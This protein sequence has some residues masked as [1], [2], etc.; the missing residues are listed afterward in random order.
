MSNNICSLSCDLALFVKRS[1]RMSEARE[2]T[3]GVISPI[4]HTPKNNP[5]LYKADLLVEK[6]VMDCI[7]FH[8]LECKRL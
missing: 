2:Q 8:V 6:A 1:Q 7:V 3:S 5:D 4:M